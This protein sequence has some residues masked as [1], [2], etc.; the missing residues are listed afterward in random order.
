MVS[1]EYKNAFV[2]AG[3]LHAQGQVRK[4]LKILEN[5]LSSGEDKERT[6]TALVKIL[7][8]Q[9][10]NNKAIKYLKQLR[11]IDP[12]SLLY[13]DTLAKLYVESGQAP[14]AIECYTNFLSN[15]PTVADA[16]YN[17]AQIQATQQQLQKAILSYQKA[18]ELNI[19]G[20]EEVHT[21]LSLIYS[22]LSMQPDAV[23]E[24]KRA[25]DKNAE[26][27]PALFNL[28][29][30]YEEQ[31]NMDL[32]EDYFKKVLSL[33][34]QHPLALARLAGLKRYTADDELVA[35]LELAAGN[36]EVQPLSQV[37]INYALGKVMDDSQQYD[38]AFETY[39]RAN[40][41]QKTLFPQYDPSRHEQFVSSLIDFFDENWFANVE[42]VSD[43]SPLFICGMFRSGSTLVEQILASHS[44]ITAGGESGY[45]PAL[46]AEDLSPFPAVLDRRNMSA[47]V[48]MAQGYTDY[49][50]ARFP[51]GDV[52][53]DKRPDNF[54]YLGL[55]KTLFPN[56][57]FIHT[58][59]N[60]IDN[61]LSVY[62]TQL[63]GQMSY[64]TDLANIAHY[65]VQQQ[66][67]MAHWCTLFSDN[68]YEANY[69]ALLADPEF[70]IKKLLSFCG[71]EWQQSCLEFHLSNNNVQ[72]A[73][74]WQVRQPLYLT[75]SGRWHN[76]H[77]HLA[78]LLSEFPDLNRAH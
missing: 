19:Q 52:I 39:R 36:T 32:A 42:A 65:Y 35:Q 70:Q 48:D 26:Y 68:I 76:Y 20:P 3:K 73:S 16:Y 12:S 10:E 33:E 21:N 67:L 58:D 5:L 40:E 54:L 27:L 37:D 74:A 28:G 53:T 72:T 22:D 77:A 56:A 25:I 18:L 2:Q 23:Q 41:I 38:K 15:N 45:F 34:A 4:A 1:R 6:L 55:I 13:C 60:A 63:A 30:R 69:E 47:L 9:A 57:I 64:A 11:K 66:R 14:S 61:C 46:M 7:L 44:Q 8:E 50:N 49:L 62:F 17:L 29:S 43:A 78:T 75:S 59:R 31:G 51:D 24:L 71:Q